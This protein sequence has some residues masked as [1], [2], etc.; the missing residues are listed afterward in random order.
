MFSYMDIKIPISYGKVYFQHVQQYSK[1]TPYQTDLASETL[2]YIKFEER[3][4]EAVLNSCTQKVD[5]WLVSTVSLLTKKGS[6]FFLFFL[7]VSPFLFLA[8]HLGKINTLIQA[9]YLIKCKHFIW[10]TF[11]H[12]CLWFVK[13]IYKIKKLILEK[14]A[15]G[16]TN[17]ELSGYGMP[18]FWLEKIRFVKEYVR[19]K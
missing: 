7:F 16:W 1:Q 10:G 6:H 9:Y 3:I 4:I 17:S 12:W 13:F 14:K 19:Y 18:L 8:T 11:S 15:R 2:R 5:L